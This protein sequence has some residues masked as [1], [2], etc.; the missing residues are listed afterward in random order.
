MQDRKLPDWIDGFLL[1]ME[2]TEPPHSYKLWTAISVL[3]SALQRKCFLRWGTITFYPNM[4]IL[5]VGPPSSRKGTAMGPGADLIRDANIP[6]ATEATSLQAIMQSMMESS[7]SIIKENR[8]MEIHSSL[9]VFSEEFTVFLGYDNKDLMTYLCRWYDCPRVFKYRTISRGVEEVQGVWLNLIGATTPELIRSSL[10]PD[11]IGGGLTSRM[12]C[13]YEE[14]KGKEVIIP[15]QTK[16]EIELYQ[17]LLYDLEKILMYNGEYKYTESFLDVWTDWRTKVANEEPK[18]VDPRLAGYLGRQ[19]AH[20]MKL[21]MIMS[22]SRGVG[23]SMVLTGDD[24]KRAIKVL[25]E[26]EI[27]MPKVFSGV[28]KTEVS[29][30]IPEVVAYISS[31]GGRITKDKLMQK[32]YVEADEFTIENVIKTLNVMN[33][34]EVDVG[35]VPNILIYTGPSIY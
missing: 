31:Q 32:F 20:V 17:Y 29:R 24:L 10:P 8:E 19:P 33:Y 1:Y 26:A 30:L 35:S 4:Y 2:N 12:I 25:E 16:E 11:A 27:K 14:K 7:N 3:A 23:P 21:S 13:I 5:L 34:L 18:F 28:G 22:A 15:I 9:T 6:I